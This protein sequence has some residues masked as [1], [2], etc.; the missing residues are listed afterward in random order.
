MTK[1]TNDYEQMDTPEVTWTFGNWAAHGIQRA[2]VEFGAGAKKNRDEAGHDPFW[3]P[4]FQSVL[5]NTY[6]LIE[7][8][9]NAIDDAEFKRHM[10]DHFREQWGALI[11]EDPKMTRQEAKDFARGFPQRVEEREAGS[12]ASLRQL[13]DTL[14]G[15]LDPD[16]L[17]DE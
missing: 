15:H 8:M 12:L 17:G 16:D 1:T 7:D 4:H 5:D 11:N 9:L 2:L 6:Y 13:L 10:T 3:V 14:T